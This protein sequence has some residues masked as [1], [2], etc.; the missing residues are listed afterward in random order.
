MI[1]P[2]TVNSLLALKDHLNFLQVINWRFTIS[3]KKW[4]RIIKRFHLFSTVQWNHQSQLTTCIWHWTVK[5]HP[6]SL[7]SKNISN[8]WHSQNF[9]VTVLLG[10]LLYWGIS[11]FLYQLSA[12]CM[13]MP[14]LLLVYGVALA[15]LISSAL[16]IQLVQY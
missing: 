13:E 14:E 4:N 9:V 10:W 5:F 8:Q 16:C 3:W 2:C 6:E 12:F 15:S 7:H 1:H 11:I